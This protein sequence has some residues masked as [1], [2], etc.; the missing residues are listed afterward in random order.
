VSATLLNELA[1]YLAVLGVSIHE[2]VALFAQESTQGV[3]EVAADLHRPGFVGVAGA[4]GQLQT[5]SGQLQNKQQIKGDEPCLGP[6][7]DGGEIDGGKSC[8]SR[9]LRFG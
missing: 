9:L 5:T 2:Q 1:K 8:G 7:L 6:G 3:G 4:A